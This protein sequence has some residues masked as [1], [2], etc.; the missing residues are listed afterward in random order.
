MSEDEHVA[1]GYR[2]ASTARLVEDGAG[3]FRVRTGVW[4]FEEAVIDVS[5]E[6]PAV[7][8]T[9][10]AALRAA[11]TGPV[12]VADHLDPGLLPIE[13]AN[14]ERLFADLAQAGMFV[15][16][17]DRDSQDAVTAALLGRMVS[18][19]PGDGEPPSGEVAF[20]SDSAAATAQAEHLAAGMRLRLAPLAPETVEH[21]AAADLTSRIDG[22]ATE[23]A[24]ADLIPA[25]TGS[26]ALVTCLQRP[27]LPLLRNINRVLESRDVP[28]VC[29]FIDG[30]FVSVVGMKS[31]HTGCFECFEQRALARL[32]DH[33]SYHDFARSPV[34]AA[35]PRAA[36]AP[37]MSLVTTMAL[38]EGYLHAAV[39]VSRLSGRVLSVHLPTL[40][41]QTQDLLRMPACPACGKVSRQRVREINF[42][43]RAAVDRIVGGVLR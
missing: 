34:G 41:I 32:E 4:N 39:G 30:P 14:I 16:A 13:S 22:L 11:A 27:S 40:E 5:R 1:D 31:P 24:V 12:R 2:L 38:T 26:A 9:V 18:P 37:M 3:R 33:V 19:Y 25:L 29:A 36:D 7:A 17:R 23:Q 6:S 43:S 8:A 20:L 42:N 10:R 35:A 15:S 21:L 28:W